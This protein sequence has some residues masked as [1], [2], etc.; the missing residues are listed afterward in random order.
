MNQHDIRNTKLLLKL[1]ELSGNWI[2]DRQFQSGQRD[3]LKYNAYA[4]V[5]SEQMN[6]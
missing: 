5:Q 6:Y 2:E 4:Y 3:L 1:L